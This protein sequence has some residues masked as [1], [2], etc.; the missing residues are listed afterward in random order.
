MVIEITGSRSRIVHLVLSEDE[1]RQRRPDALPANELL[2]WQPRCI[3]GK[4]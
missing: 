3:A 2:L 4:V 1:S